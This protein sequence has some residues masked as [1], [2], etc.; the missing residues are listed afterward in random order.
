M[1]LVQEIEH[2]E[3]VGNVAELLTHY[4][5]KVTADP[6]FEFMTQ[7]QSLQMEKAGKNLSTCTF[8]VNVVLTVHLGVN[9]SRIVNRDIPARGLRYDIQK[10]ITK[11]YGGGLATGAFIRFDG[12]NR[13]E[14]CDVLYVSN[15]DPN[16][17]H[18]EFFMQEVHDGGKVIWTCAAAGQVTGGRQSST[19]V[20]REFADGKLSASRGPRKLVG[21]LSLRKLVG[22]FPVD[23]TP[24][25]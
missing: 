24:K 13:P 22:T 4:V 7:G 17:E 14:K 11:M 10:S 2:E 5:P 16:S 20:E 8:L 19:Y 12:A 3:L 6:V 1:P 9:D 25:P 23:F 15:G 18:V 21:W